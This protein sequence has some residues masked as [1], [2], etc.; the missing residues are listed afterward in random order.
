MQGMKAEVKTGKVWLVGA[1][2]GDAGLL[3]LRGREVLEEA[4]SVVYDA[5][6]G[7]GILGW[8]PEGARQIYVGKR[9]GSH[10]KSQEE[11]NQILVNEALQGRRVVRLKGGDPFV[12]GRGSEEAQVLRSYGIP[13]E[14]VPGVTSAVAVPA[15]C[16][17][18][19]THRGI[20]PSFHVITGHRKNGE[21]ADMDY[22]AIVK[23]GG[24]LIFLMGVTSAEHICQ[25]LI[26]GGMTKDT[27]AALLERGTT[28]GQRKVISTVER[29]WEDGKQAG[30]KPP[31]IIVVGE[32]CSLSDTCGWLEEKPLFGNKVLVTRPRRRSA[33]MAKRLREA[34]AEV[35]ELP[36]AEP[37]LVQAEEDLQKLR[38]MVSQI[39]SFQWAVFTSPSGVELFFEFM[40]Q[41][42]IDLRT[43][44]GLRFAAIGEGTR[45]E[46]QSHGFFADYMPER[47]YAEDL[48]KGLADRLLKETQNKKPGR[49]LL[50]R[51]RK[52]S[53]ALPRE[54]S[55]AGIEF[56][57]TALYDT[58]LPDGSAQTERV[59][60]L[61]KKQEFSF[62]TF[63]SASTVEGF[64]R[65]LKPDE[66][67]LS[68][69]TA[70]CIGEETKKAAEAAGMRTVV[71]D[72]PSMDSMVERME[73]SAVH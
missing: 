8:I 4:Q 73:R 38:K 2:P 30:I 53:E 61:L 13:F 25:E 14:I 6:V 31:A 40:K 24:T 10:T 56:E 33:G 63:T 41:E 45:R 70:V 29:V 15:Y 7:D 36:A 23:E 52:A 47:Y 32:V 22:A 1:G 18:P 69:F 68:G 37:R 67:E 17:I 35:V 26:K 27:P 16:G 12:F 65:L 5:L 66:E 44:M 55:A 19:V 71:S 11:I 3:T 48:G 64:L 28:A 42:K 72:V 43:L 49:V 34:G 60:E 54:L 57:E 58:L 46:L 39:D 59:K 62:V 20:A 21:P 50:L 9:G 51:A